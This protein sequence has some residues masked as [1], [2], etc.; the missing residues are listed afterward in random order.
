[1]TARKVKPISAEVVLESRRR[2]RAGGGAAVGEDDIQVVTWDGGWSIASLRLTTFIQQRTINPNAHS[3]SALCHFGAPVEII[4]WK[5]C[6][7]W[8]WAVTTQGWKFGEMELFCISQQRNV[9]THNLVLN[10]NV[11]MQD[12]SPRLCKLIWGKQLAKSE[13]IKVYR[14]VFYKDVCHE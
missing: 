14:L 1:M 3:R 6:T 9:N 10:P 2:A 7:I 12:E 11:S 13:M 4:C 5:W 8:S